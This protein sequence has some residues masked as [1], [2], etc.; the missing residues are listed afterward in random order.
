M[1]YAKQALQHALEHRER[2]DEAYALHLHG[3]IEARLDPSH[4]EAAGY[5]YLQALEL[6]RELGM[7][8]LVAR[9]HLGLGTLKRQAGHA[10]QA[11]E[12]LGFAVALFREMGMP[13][14]AERAAGGPT[15]R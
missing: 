7:Q 15:L 12:H 8:P 11:D 2:G 4:L 6:A 9:C 13:A 3:E 10:R 5:H 14:W 1:A